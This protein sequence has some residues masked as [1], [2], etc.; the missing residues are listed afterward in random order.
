M[1]S[2]SWAR[3]PAPGAPR[4]A[5][6]AGP[7]RMPDFLRRGLAGDG[8]AMPSWAPVPCQNRP[9]ASATRA[10]AKACKRGSMPTSYT[11]RLQ[12]GRLGQGILPLGHSLFDLVQHEMSTSKSAS[13]STACHSAGSSVSARTGWPPSVRQPGPPRPPA[14]AARRPARPLP[15]LRDRRPRPRRGRRPARRGPG[16]GRRKPCAPTHEGHRFLDLQV[17]EDLPVLD[18]PPVFTRDES[19]EAQQL[20]GAAGLFLGAERGGAEAAQ[21]GSI[22]ATREAAS[23]GSAAEALTARPSKAATN[24]RGPRRRGCS[25]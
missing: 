3:R 8:L 25:S 11:R 5:C 14:R 24:P 4:R 22:S 9:S 23:P 19:Q 21:A 13:E 15:G 20:P 10:G 12:A 17:H 1:A 16:A 7:A 18:A 2:G 6:L